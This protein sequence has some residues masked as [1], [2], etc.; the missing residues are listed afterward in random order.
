M[1]ICWGGEGSS[2]FWQCQD[3]GSACCRCADVNAGADADDI[4]DDDIA[5]ANATIYIGAHPR[6]LDV[7]LAKFVQFLLS[8]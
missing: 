7:L 5:D 4:T 6:L 1:L 2:Q 3:L 8:F